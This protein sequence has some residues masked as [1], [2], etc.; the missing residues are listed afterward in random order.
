MVE[1]A[2][3][4]ICILAHRYGLV[5]LGEDISITEMEYDKAVELG[6]P[7]LVFFM[8]DEHPVSPKH[9]EKGAGAEKLDR[10]KA[11]IGQE[12]VAAFFTTPEDLRGHVV[13]AL[14]NL[15]PTLGEDKTSTQRS[16]E[17]LH[18]RGAI[19]QAPAEYVAHPY[20]LLQ[21][22]DLVGRQL[23]LR[24]L[25]DW[26]SEPA[27]AAYR[28]RIF[29]LIAIGGMGK[30]AL[31]WKWFREIAPQEA[32]DLAGR[33][34]WSFY[35]SDATF[36]N[37]VLHALAYVSGDD[38]ADLKKLPR[39][40][41]EDRLFRHLDEEPHLIAMDGPERAM[42]AYARVDASRLADDELDRHTANRVVGAV[43]LPKTAADSFVGQHRLRQML[44]PRDGA[45]LRRLTQARAS[46]VLITSRLYP[47][48]LQMVTG[49]PAAGCFGLFLNGLTEDD[50]LAL[51]RELGVTGKRAELGPIFASVEGHLLLI[52]ALAKEVAGHRAAPGDFGA[53]RAA[54]PLFEIT[55]L[56][57]AEA[58][59]HILDF[60]LRGL[61]CAAR[62]ALEHIVTF[63]MPASYDSLSAVLIGEGKD[64]ADAGALDRALTE[65]EDRG[66]VGWDRIANRYDAHPIVRGVVWGL[67][68]A[69]D[70]S[71]RFRALEAHFEPMQTPIDW[72]EV[73]SLADLSPA[74]ERYHM[75]LG[76]GRLDDAL[77]L[78]KDRMENATFY[79]LAAHR[80]RIGWLTPLFPD[81]AERA[82]ALTSARDQSFAMNALAGS[83]M[84]SGQPGAAVAL[85]RNKVALDEAEG[86]EV[87]LEVGLHNLGDCL[88]E[89]GAFRAAE[90]A[91]RRELVLVRNLESEFDEATA[92]LILGG[93][94]G[95]CGAGDEPDGVRAA[96]PD[97]ARPAFADGLR[98]GGG[99]RG[100]GRRLGASG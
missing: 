38:V 62:E 53:S 17:N 98:P 95:F 20:T 5:P 24:L 36:W 50:A 18:R 70:R 65:L 49:D 48:E 28:A 85:L 37:F 82:P 72:T 31:T 92:L 80:E 12:R 86:G 29:N 15:L 27:S 58:R 10:L 64:C 41:V 52:H 34:W 69:E 77:A 47:S 23:E 33:M 22:Q 71:A 90:T 66:L 97:L 43:G 59:T 61:D 3:I 54:H 87:E 7:R 6:R 79:R 16:Q 91:L 9:V 21:A 4:Y 76:L 11:R 74:I 14:A 93:V 25:T 42:I 19:P 57:V 84:L 96:C 75:L 99:A 73:E 39:K 100:A 40:D 94:L 81:G 83:Y 56:N 55:T 35:E 63:N 32:P 89:I 51:W 1:E 2:D 44:D 46:R 13:E 68:G 67:I 30:S 8:D 26:V 60:A 88:T 78:F 45:F